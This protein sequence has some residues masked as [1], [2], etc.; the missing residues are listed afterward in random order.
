MGLVDVNKRIL[1]LEDRRDMRVIVENLLS[2]NG[3]EVTACGSLRDAIKILRR[4]SFRLALVDISMV[5]GDWQDEQGTALLAEIKDHYHSDCVNAIVMTAYGTVQRARDA[6]K[7]YEVYDYVEKS[8]DDQSFHHTLLDAV[9]NGLAD[10]QGRMLKPRSRLPGPRKRQFEYIDWIV[11]VLGPEPEP[12]TMLKGQV[13]Y[14]L[15][16]IALR[17][18]LAPLALPTQPLEIPQKHGASAYFVCW[19]RALERMMLVEV[20]RGDL[21]DPSCEEWIK[22]F[23]WR[24][25]RMSSCSQSQ[26]LKAS[27][28]FLDGLPFERVFGSD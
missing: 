27:A 14:V 9:K 25:D 19:S 17:N 2:E 20:A 7:K 8:A 13:A 18:D 5:H 3:Y 26:L 11:D 16:D 15:E 24:L 6:F 12:T 1:V 28:F 23:G 4:R 22:D 10:A 21:I